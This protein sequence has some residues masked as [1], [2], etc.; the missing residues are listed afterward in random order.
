MGGTAV[1]KIQRKTAKDR[2]PVR[3]IPNLAVNLYEMN[4]DDV[5]ETTG[6]VIIDSSLGMLADAPEE[7][8]ATK[9]TTR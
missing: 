4:A 5:F 1:D 9:G 8:S 2:P 6:H 7:P 3:R